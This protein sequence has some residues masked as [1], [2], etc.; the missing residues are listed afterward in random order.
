V[1][2]LIGLGVVVWLV[3][4]VLVWALPREQVALPGA[5]ATPEQVVTAYLEALNARDFSTSNEIDARS[6]SDHGLFSLPGRIRLERI[7]KVFV[8]GGQA[9]VTFHADFEGGD[10]SLSG[11]Q[12]WG[13]YLD[14]DQGGRWQITDA[15]VA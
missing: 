2:F 1:R 8:D 15:G 7:D 10:G 5:D 4:V 13:Y 12:L 3:G 9:H 6:R 14:R 11:R